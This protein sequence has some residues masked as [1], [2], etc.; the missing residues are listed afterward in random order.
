[1]IQ[2]KSRWDGSV[3][4]RSESASTVKEAVEEA[5]RARAPLAG[6][7][8]A[9]ANL[10][11]ATLPNGMIWELYKLDPMAGICD[12]PAARDRAAAAWDNHSWRDC[13]MHAAYGWNGLADAPT[14]KRRDVACFVAVF[15]ARLLPKPQPR[16][17]EGANP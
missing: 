11:G 15:D 5:V 2:I 14:D 7:N 10:T 16:T 13:P 4:Y 8:L 12:E 17:T 6:A 9:D 1:M 3:V